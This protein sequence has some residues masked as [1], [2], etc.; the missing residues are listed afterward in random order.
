MHWKNWQHLCKPKS[1]GGLGFRKLEA[2]NLAML[3]KQVWRMLTK[4]DT[5]V[6]RVFKARYFLKSSILN[7]PLSSRPSYAWRSLHAAQKLIAKGARAI[8]GNGENTSLWEDPWINEKPA[9]PLTASRCLHGSN[10]VLLSNC[11]T[12]KDLLTPD[13]REWNDNLLKTLFQEEDV[14]KIE[15]IRPAGLI[16]RDSYSWDFTSFGKYSVKS[17]YWVAANLLKE[18]TTPEVL[19]PSLDTIFQSLWKTNTYPKIH[20]FIWRALSDCLSVGE[21]LRYRHLA[22][23]G[24][25]PRC[26]ASK[27]TA[28]HVLF[29]CPYARLIWAISP[30]PAPP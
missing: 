30:I 24:S 12:V 20:H 15:A 7:A 23:D 16:C 5:L 9:R 3:G 14:R 21:N 11:T 29:K 25:C 8:I 4:S 26:G 1:E 17:G 10:Q 13:G 18:E 28:N 22:K 2:F 19:Q 27:E 6:A